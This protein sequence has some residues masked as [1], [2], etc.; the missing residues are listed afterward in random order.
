MLRHY[1]QT[2]DELKSLV[3]DLSINL[4][5]IETC[6]VADMSALFA[7]TKRVDFSGIEFWD[8]SKVENMAE[9]FLGAKGF[10]ADISCWDT[11]R[12]KNMR[13]MFSNCCNIGILLY[14]RKAE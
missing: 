9:M 1:P 12:V 4:G 3:N 11:S 14:F 10:N 8:T 6:F 13:S 5:D 7:N 2:K